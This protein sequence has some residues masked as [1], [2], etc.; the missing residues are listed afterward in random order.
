MLINVNSVEEEL[1]K[2][3]NSGSSNF[4]QK[5]I[6]LTII[7]N[8]RPTFLKVILK[9]LIGILTCNQVPGKAVNF[10]IGLLRGTQRR[11]F[12]AHFY[13]R[14]S[15]SGMRWKRHPIRRRAAQRRLRCDEQ[16]HLLAH[17]RRYILARLLFRTGSRTM[18]CN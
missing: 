6:L 14:P 13:G 9:F 2:N 1:T 5:A 17:L 10:S 16:C 11:I 12:S 18:V 15:R 8:Q 7:H 4:E 3:V